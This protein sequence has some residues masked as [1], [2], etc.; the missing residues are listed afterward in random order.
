MYELR[1]EKINNNKDR[2][3]KNCYI[4]GTINRENSI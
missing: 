3:N 1:R 2:L 4:Y